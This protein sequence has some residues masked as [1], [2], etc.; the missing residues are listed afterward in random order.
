MITREEVLEK[1]KR[2]I[3][4]NEVNYRVSKQNPNNHGTY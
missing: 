4:D 3:A 1:A 2:I